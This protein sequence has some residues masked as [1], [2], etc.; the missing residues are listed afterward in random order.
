MY[1]FQTKKHI[2]VNERCFATELPASA[3]MT[4]DWILSLKFKFVIKENDFVTLRKKY[5]MFFIFLFDQ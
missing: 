3:N 4:T 1:L 2:T 5:K